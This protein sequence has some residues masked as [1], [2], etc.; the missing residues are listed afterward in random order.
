MILIPQSDDELISRYM[1]EV[2]EELS[3]LRIEI[4][5]LKTYLASITTGSDAPQIVTYLQGVE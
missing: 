5:E 1:R 3:R 2:A 4:E